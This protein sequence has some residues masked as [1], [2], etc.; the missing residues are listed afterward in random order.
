M[1]SVGHHSF[2]VSR[3]WMRRFGFHSCKNRKYSGAFLPQWYICN[4]TCEIDYMDEFI[5]PF[6]SSKHRC[7]AKWVQHLGLRS[8]NNFGRLPSCK[9]HF[10]FKICLL[11][12][13]SIKNWALLPENS[14]KARKKR[15]RRR[16][17]LQISSDLLIN[18]FY[19]L[20]GGTIC[21]SHNCS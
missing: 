20:A 9:D 3:H 5:L 12:L 16:H 2:Y 1:I 10:S 21:T 6:N 17:L 11:D 4:N 18:F 14:K 7:R 15:S 8:M 19:N 13:K